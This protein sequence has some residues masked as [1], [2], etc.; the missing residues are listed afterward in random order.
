[1][2]KHT[3]LC[4]NSENYDQLIG[5]QYVLFMK[6]VN[7]QHELWLYDYVRQNNRLMLLNAPSI[8]KIDHNKRTSQ[9]TIPQSSSFYFINGHNLLIGVYNK[10]KPNK[11]MLKFYN[12]K[13]NCNKPSRKEEYSFNVT[14]TSHYL[15]DN[16]LF[17]HDLIV[18]IDTFETN[19]LIPC[20]NN[21][22]SICPCNR[23]YSVQKDP[24]N[25]AF[26]TIDN[27]TF[28]I[29]GNYCYVDTQYDTYIF[30]SKTSDSTG[31]N[32][33]TFIR[34]EL[35][36]RKL[37]DIK[38]INEKINIKFRP[39]MFDIYEVDIDESMTDLSTL[40]ELFDMLQDALNKTDIMITYDIIPNNDSYIFELRDNHKYHKMLKQYTLKKV[41][42]EVTI[43][44][45][46][47]Y[48]LNKLESM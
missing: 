35:E 38:F 26:F 6:Y 32:T 47:D 2:I 9:Y 20:Q 31:N 17:Y 7:S 12:L 48:V 27:N 39:K 14:Q 1:M 13:V 4:G 42:D 3:I 8:H 15:I 22:L 25:H 44:Q 37:T 30:R 10:D 36:T 19:H 40:E 11:L 18:N 23:L 46:L 29:E 5:D 45:K 21:T 16:K 33:F 41:P 24:T 28:I 43:D 34:K